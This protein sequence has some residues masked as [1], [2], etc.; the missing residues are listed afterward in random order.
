SNVESTFSMV[1]A[2]FG[3]SLRSKDDTAQ[4]NE[5]LCKILCHNI[6]C[7]I[8]SMYELGIEPD[9]GTGQIEVEKVAETV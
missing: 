5:A 3:D 1:K 9:F 6:C 7:V 2:K 8:Q 4:E